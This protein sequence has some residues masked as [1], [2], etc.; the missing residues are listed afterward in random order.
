[1]SKWVVAAFTIGLL[2]ACNTSPYEGYKRLGDDVYMHLQVLGDGEVIPKDGDSLLIRLRMG[3][4]GGEIGELLSTE[5]W[6]AAKD[7]R[8]D[9]FGDVLHRIHEG[10]SM[11]VIAPVQKWP[12][13]TLLDDKH[14]E[15]PDT[16]MVRVELSLVRIRTESMRSLE[17]EQL[18]T[19]E[20]YIYE[21]KLIHAYLKHE[22][23]P[24]ERW[25][26]SDMY[27]RLKTPAR[28]TITV[29]N[30]D[31][32]T[33]SY[34]GKNM[35]DGIVFDDTKR[36]GMPLTFRMGDKDQVM[37]GLGY[38]IEI[39]QEGQEGIFLFPSEFAFGAKGVPGIV[40]PNMPVIYTVHL[41]KVDRA[42]GQRSVQ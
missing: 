42:T 34:R 10:D 36:N 20:P 22:K 30:G 17:D 19:S 13:H 4:V 35:E 24:F 28:D 16:G 6:Y 27:Y 8:K 1:M 41:D 33:I 11:S 38:A 29:K 37:Q 25:G 9:A 15:A 26:T 39:L 3:L 32:V 2:T 31:M 21:R 14:A 40:D 23:V 7:L 18:R 12:W 5:E